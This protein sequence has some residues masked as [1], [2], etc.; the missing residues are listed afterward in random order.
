MCIFASVHGSVDGLTLHG[1]NRVHFDMLFQAFG[2]FDSLSSIGEMKKL[3][4]SMIGAPNARELKE[5][6]PMCFPAPA[7]PR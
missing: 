1:L 6:V 3:K 7:A 2:A 5:V 4:I